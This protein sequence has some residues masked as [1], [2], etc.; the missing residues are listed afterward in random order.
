MDGSF[1]NEGISLHLLFWNCMKDVSPEVKVENLKA[2][3]NTAYKEGMYTDALRW[4][5][6]A[7]VYVNCSNSGEK[8]DHKCLLWNNVSAALI[9]LGCW[10]AALFHL[11]KVLSVDKDNKKALY[12][13]A[14]CL[15][16]LENFKDAIELLCRI[17][18]P[19]QEIL[20]LLEKAKKL[21]V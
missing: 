3:G 1:P 21:F 19:C 18:S 5:R 13:T 4:Y 16:E 6:I 8:E 11:E 2:I 10:K 9:G 15:T 20:D 7:L 17:S 14:K 12:R